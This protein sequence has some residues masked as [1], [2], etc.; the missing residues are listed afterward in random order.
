MVDDDRMEIG[1]LKSMGFSNTHI[2]FKYLLYSA[3]ATIVGGVIGAVLGFLTIPKIIWNI[4]KILFDIPKFVTKLDMTYIVI[5]V[6]IS[7]VCIVGVTLITVAKNLREKPSKL[8]RPKAP[9]KGK[10]V[11]LEYIPV[12]WKHISFSNKVTIR[13]I[14]RYKA[15]VFMTVFGVA[16]CTA[17]L[18]AGF[19]LRDSIVNIPEKQYR[20]IFTYDDMLY[21]SPLITDDEIDTLLNADNIKETAKTQYVAYTSAKNNKNIEVTMVVPEDTNNFIKIFNLRDARTHKELEILDDEIII[22]DKMAQL[23][24]LSVG[25]NISIF[26]SQNNE[27]IFT[28]GGICE[29]YVNH[30]VFINKNTYE[31]NIGQYNTNTAFIKTLAMTDKEEDEF[32]TELLDNDKVC[33]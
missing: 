16:G 23:M 6:L 30:F 13:N 19:G 5:G 25:D 14:F 18:M 28:I 26:D 3:I 12:L 15:R 9:K 20:D 1:T 21:F 24:K 7:F 11:I 33:R 32:R 10:R 27:Y 8:L 29:Q 31:K 4:Y 22:S 2:A 17:L